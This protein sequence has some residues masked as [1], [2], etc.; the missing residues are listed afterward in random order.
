MESYK[1]GGGMS[2]KQRHLAKAKPPSLKERQSDPGEGDLG[3][4]DPHL[5]KFKE[6]KKGG[7]GMVKIVLF[8]L[9]T[10]ILCVGI[11]VVLMLFVPDVRDAI[12]PML[13]QSLQQMFEDAA[14]PPSDS[15]PA[16]PA[17]TGE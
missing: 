14:A 9:L 1:E 2:P 10:L 4:T 17:E 3:P 5:K 11:V 8:L 13:P 15:T 16:T 6:G 12:R 7:T